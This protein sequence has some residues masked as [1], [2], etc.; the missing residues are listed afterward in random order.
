MGSGRPHGDVFCDCP[1]CSTYDADGRRAYEAQHP[2]GKCQCEECNPWFVKVSFPTEEDR[3]S[4]ASVVEDYRA[5]MA[6]GCRVALAVTEYSPK[7][8]VIDLTHMPEERQKEIQKE[9]EKLRFPLLVRDAAW[10]GL[11]RHYPSD[12]IWHEFEYN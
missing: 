11:M 8:V 6:A 3:N 10:A 5:K 4:F 12:P 2:K 9:L 7:P 1:T